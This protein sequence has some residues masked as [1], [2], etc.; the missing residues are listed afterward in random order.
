MRRREF[1][2]LFGGAAA[3]WPLARA[4]SRA[5]ACGASAC[6]CR[7]RRR[8]GDRRASAAFVQGLAATGL[9][10]RPQH[11][12]RHPL[13]RR[14]A[15][16][17]RRYAEELVALGPDVIWLSGAA[18]VR[19]CRRPAPCRSCSRSPPI[20]SAPVCRE[21]GAAGR[22]RHRFHRI[23]IQH[24]GKWLELLK[25][26]APGV[27]RVAVIR[28]PAIPAGRSVC[29]I[30]AVAPLLGV[31]VSAVNV[32]DAAEI[33]RAVT[34]FARAPNGGLI[35]TAGAAD[36]RSSRIDRHPGGPAQ[37]AC[38]LLRFASSSLPAA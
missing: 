21:P 17:I 36:V 16:D 38:G 8:C 25:E 35:V 32:R 9:D 22:Q 3:A 5:N 30:Q 10:H 6:C 31:E 4:R 24:S 34:A 29:A 1:I 26:I 2:N 14:D 28:D 15:D 12:H 20:R 27:P 33:E 37:A 23:R 19:C 13:G 18:A 11:A 7:G